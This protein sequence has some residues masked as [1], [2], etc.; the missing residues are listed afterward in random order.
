MIKN[1][2]QEIK[3]GSLAPGADVIAGK[4]FL[5]NLILSCPDGIID[6]NREGTVIIFNKAA[7]NLTG[8][9][10]EDVLHKVRITEI[11]N[12]PELARDIKKRSIYP[13]G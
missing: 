4:E 11:Y 10:T 5:D 12:S 6:I 8:Y 3:D 13:E 1:P 7:E 2:T 9:R